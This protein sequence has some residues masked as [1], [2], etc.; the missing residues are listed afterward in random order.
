MIKTKTTANWK[1]I[2]L[3]M[4]LWAAITFIVAIICWLV[5]APDEGYAIGGFFAGLTSAAL[6][7][8]FF[9]PWNIEV[10]DDD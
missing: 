8:E 7:C 9:P 4:L 2:G 6:G 3:M 5:G 1:N 10:I